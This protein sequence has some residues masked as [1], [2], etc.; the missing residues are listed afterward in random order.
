V[1]DLGGSIDVL[2]ELGKGTRFEIWLPAT[3]DLHQQVIEETRAAPLG[4]GETV[5]IVDDEQALVALSEE[6]LAELGY[7]PIGFD[8]SVAALQ[9]LQGQPQR[10]DIILSDEAM[11]DLTGTDLAR[12]IRKLRPDI[13]IVLMSGYGG[14]Q[15][16]A[17]AA[18]CG[19]SEVLRKPLQNR[20]L[21][22]ALARARELIREPS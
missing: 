11:P 15:L 8:S 18:S 2:S 12:E 7:E 3:R 6:L 9:A 22:E 17:R 5:M 4:N 14:A 19:V 13:P 1:T 16:A 10:F 21:A 20:E